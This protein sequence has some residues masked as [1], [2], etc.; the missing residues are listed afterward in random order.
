MDEDLM[1]MSREELLDEVVKLRGAIRQHRDASGHDLCWWHPA[2]WASLP[3]STDPIP[4]VPSWEQFMRGCVRYRASLDEQ[5]PDAPRISEEYR[6]HSSTS[7]GA[8]KSQP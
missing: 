8:G 6:E 4:E 7:H 3:A 2:L 5:L 1:Q